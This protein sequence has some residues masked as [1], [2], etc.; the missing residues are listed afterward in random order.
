[1]RAVTR[2]RVRLLLFTLALSVMV[3]VV[4]GGATGPMH[5]PPLLALALGALSGATIGA[6]LAVVIGGAEI[7]LPHT[8]LGQALDRAPFVVAFGAKWMFYSGAIV[9]VLGS[10]VGRR[11]ASLVLGLEHAHAPD[12]HMTTTSAT[13]GV[14]LALL[15]S[16]AFSLLFDLGDLV[17][18]RTLR[19]IVLGRY[20][21]PRAEERFF[22]FID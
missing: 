7:F 13:L 18:Q 8:R 11:V 20:H 14:A 6:I 19:D 22:L 3:G 9:L 5:G 12:P 4:I 21:R 15:V 17:G 1:M 2:R 10:M 16:F